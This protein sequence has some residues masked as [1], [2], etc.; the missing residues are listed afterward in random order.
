[1][2][3]QTFIKQQLCLGFLRALLSAPHLFFS[4]QDS[5]TVRKE[6]LSSSFSQGADTFFRASGLSK[7]LFNRKA[8]DFE[9][10]FRFIFRFFKEDLHRRVSV[11]DLAA[12]FS[13]AVVLG[14]CVCGCVE[15]PPRVCGGRLTVQL[16]T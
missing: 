10:R 8:A 7:I 14:V 3:E 1:M 13:A 12:G 4:F 9:M 15:W 5:P 6:G 16:F 11:K 2:K